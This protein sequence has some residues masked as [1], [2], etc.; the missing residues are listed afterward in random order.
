[1]IMAQVSIRLKIS[2]S[3][4]ERQVTLLLIHNLA[5]TF[6]FFD[7]DKYPYACEKLQVDETLVRCPS[8]R[9]EG[10]TSPPLIIIPTSNQGG[11]LH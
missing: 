6:H 2:N 9:V 5:I 10:V 3:L 11:I 7:A 1:M 4:D 8:P